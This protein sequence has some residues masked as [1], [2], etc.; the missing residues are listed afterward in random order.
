M[1]EA[2]YQ[3]VQRLYSYV[4]AQEKRIKKLEKTITHIINDVEEI[5]TKPPLQ[6]ET[7]EYKFDQLKVE[8]LEG[9]LNVGLNPA[10]LQGI[11][12][13]SVKQPEPP[14]IGPKPIKLM[15][16]LEE[17]LFSY[18]E[19]DLPA[20][21]ND[22]EKQLG[23]NLDESY[24]EFIKQDIRKQLP[25]RI[26]HYLSEQNSELRSKDKHEKVKEATIGKV[27]HDIHTAVF[28]FLSRLP[29]DQ[30]GEEDNGTANH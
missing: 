10:D 4:T 27:K 1:S 7:I 8:S 13:F 5:K 22:T 3:Y 9:T 15:R 23:L 24:I 29:K 20:V 21:I 19:I 26:N 16:E 28:A 18:L 6:V 14:F 17:E 2:V 25:A 30:K 12:E 11:D